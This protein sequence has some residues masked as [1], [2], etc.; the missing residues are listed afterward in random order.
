M[1]Q[2]VQPDLFL[3]GNAFRDLFAVECVILGFI[4]LSLFKSA[5]VCFHVRRL[6]EGSD[7]R[8]RQKGKVEAL[9]LDRFTHGKGGG[10]GVIFRFDRRNF[11]LYV[12]VFPAALF[13]E[14]GG[15]G[16]KRR[17]GGRVLRRTDL[18]ELAQFVQL[19]FGKGKALFAFLGQL[20]FVA[21]RVRDM[22]QRAGGGEHDLCPPFLQS[23]Y[24]AERGG[25]M[26]FPNIFT[27]D[28][29]G[30][31][32]FFGGESV[33]LNKRKAFTPFDKVEPDPV[34]GERAQFLIAIADIAEVGLYE[35]VCPVFMRQDAG[36]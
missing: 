33:F 24:G 23:L 16:L 25:I 18:F 31:E 10:A 3:Q 4:D 19:F 14:K 28:K 32:R 7:R 34:K 20:C 6:R 29:P 26:V 30:K 2:D 17:I 9:F 27:V 5:A 15:V 13:G 36:V 8:C 12:G 11:C 22:Q 21:Q 1:Y 35:N